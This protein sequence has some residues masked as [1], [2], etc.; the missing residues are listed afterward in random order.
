MSSRD[1][2]NVK[3]TSRE[4]AM[5]YGS[6]APAGTGAPTALVGKG[7]TLARTGVGVFR[8][9]L[10]KVYP[11]LLA[12][13]LTLQL[14][15]GDDKIMQMGDVDL[16]AKTIDLRIWDISGAAVVDVAA[17]ANNRVN[18]ILAFQNSSVD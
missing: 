13:H 15:T 16:T 4:V 17:D 14:S 9:T 8:L 3:A 11:T 5:I 18:F 10:D 6:F 12:A 1:L 2:R 7:I